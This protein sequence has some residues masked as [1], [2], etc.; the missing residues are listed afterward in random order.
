LDSW[1]S[2]DPILEI[3]NSLVTS[4]VCSQSDIDV[5]RQ[6][7]ESEVDVATEKAKAAPFPTINS[8]FDELY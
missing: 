4:G 2:R 3:G 5:W 1:K 8:L 7:F 6:A